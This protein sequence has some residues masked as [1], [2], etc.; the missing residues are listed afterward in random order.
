MPTPMSEP[1]PVP[2]DVPYRHLVIE[3]LRVSSVEVLPAEAV[4]GGTRVTFRVAVSDAVGQPCP[5]LAVEARIAGP[6]RTAVGTAVT[7]ARGRAR[8]RMTGPMGAY[9]CEVLD[10][11]A[12][13]LRIT[14]EQAPLASASTTLAEPAVSDG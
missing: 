9:A 13:A 1:G 4:E 8:F 2:D 5:D 14:P 10:V 11:G 3:P 6:A 7:D 12:G